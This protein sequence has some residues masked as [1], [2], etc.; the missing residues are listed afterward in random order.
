V[1]QLTPARAA[2]STFVPTP[3]VESTSTGRS[4]PAG[5][6]TMPLKAPSRPSAS[7]VRVVRASSAMRRRAS[8]A[9]SRCT[10]AAA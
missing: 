7:G 8:S 4:K 10:P 1:H 9:A 3:S 2:T 6:R 5:T